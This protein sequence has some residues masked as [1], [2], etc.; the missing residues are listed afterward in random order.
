MHINLK[1]KKGLLSSTYNIYS[2]N[3][4]VGKLTDKTFSQ[5]AIG[6]LDGKKYTFRTTGIFNQHTE[7]LDNRENKVIGTITYNSWMTKATISISGKTI[8]WKYGNVWQT[9]WSIFDS[10]GIKINYTGSST[11]GNIESSTDDALLVLSGLFVT[12]YYWQMFI[13]IL[14][15]VFVPLWVTVLN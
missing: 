6:E 13:V 14:V 12:N 7:I 4:L 15:A 10:G 11:N 5:S 8:N 3:Q 1:W 9:K 2:K